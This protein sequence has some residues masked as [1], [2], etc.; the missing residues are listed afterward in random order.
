MNDIPAPNRPYMIKLKPLK[1][2]DRYP[3][4]ITY[5]FEHRNM[6]KLE[7]KI[8]TPIMNFQSPPWIPAFTAPCEKVLFQKNP[9]AF[10]ENFKRRRDRGNEEELKLLLFPRPPRRSRFCGICRIIYDED[11]Y[12]H[13]TSPN[14]NESFDNPKNPENM[15]YL[16]KL[17]KVMEQVHSDF[18]KSREQYTTEVPSSPDS[19]PTIKKDTTSLLF[20]FDQMEENLANKQNGIENRKTDTQNESSK[21]NIDLRMVDREYKKLIQPIQKINSQKLSPTKIR[22]LL[23]G[24]KG[25]IQEESKGDEENMKYKVNLGFNKG[26]LGLLDRK[27]SLKPNNILKKHVII[28]AKRSQDEDIITGENRGLTR[29]ITTDENLRIT[30]KTNENVFR[31]ASWMNSTFEESKNEVPIP[32]L[33]MNT[34]LTNLP[35]RSKK[36]SHSGMFD[37]EQEELV[38]ELKR[39]RLNDMNSQSSVKSENTRI[40]IELGKWQNFKSSFIGFLGDLKGGVNKLYGYLV[41]KEPHN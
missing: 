24:T 27:D 25:A 9:S 41:R 19:S 3:N 26:G 15:Q 8:D 7:S 4:A 5:D 17:H 11:Y 22:S 31:Y 35:I 10:E 12:Q 16:P 20:D 38:K 1:P 6:K 21:E 2:K 34:D 36:R 32:N 13:A 30:E 23:Y 40:K 39:V 18:L 28:T 37:E 14:H 29:S 33:F